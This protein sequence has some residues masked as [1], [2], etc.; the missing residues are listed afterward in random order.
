MRR[1]LLFLPGNN[2]NMIMNGGLLGADS[3]ILDL[4]DAV[5]PDNKDEARELVASALTSLKFGSCDIIVRV[6]GLDT[7]YWKED[8]AQIIPCKPFAIMP[9]K[10]SSAEYLLAYD[11]EMARLEAQWGMEVGSVRLIPLIE[12]ALGL[13]NAYAIAC[14]SSRVEGI[15]LGAEDLTADLQC[16]RT[17]EGGEIAYARARMVSAARAAGVEAYDT[18]FTNVEDPEGL[19]A[20]TQ[21]GK[22][23]GFSGK[24]AINPRQVAVI[25]RIY[26][27]T[28]QQ[29]RYAKEVFRAIQEGKAQGKGA[30]SLH[31]KM[32]DA[33]IV[34]RAK[35][36]LDTARLLGLEEEYE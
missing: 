2:P 24:S 1:T 16:Q 14:A 13:E 35:T 21:T 30:V 34:Q 9:A 32:I 15:F 33:P 8:L 25:N 36:V 26:S 23:L 12:T 22:A 27:P 31:G 6:N 4:E 19:Q 29:I 28:Q 7:P 5:A 10:V 17:R 3:I 18:P 20:D 11:R